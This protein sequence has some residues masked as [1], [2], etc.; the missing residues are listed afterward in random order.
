MYTRLL[1]PD[2]NFPY[3]KYVVQ[4]FIPLCE[5]KVF[6]TQHDRILFDPPILAA[7]NHYFIAKKMPTRGSEATCLETTHQ[8]LF[9]FALGQLFWLRYLYGKKISLLIHIFQEL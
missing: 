2:Q 1:E 5:K 4:A 9:L 6:K 8:I 3:T 7:F